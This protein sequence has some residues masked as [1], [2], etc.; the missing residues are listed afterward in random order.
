[1]RV[2][3]VHQNF[4]GQFKSLAPALAAR[5]D[6][7]HAFHMT[8]TSPMPGVTL[9]RSKTTIGTGKDGHPWSRDFDTKIIRAEAT[10]RTARALAATGWTPDVIFAHSGWGEPTFLKLVWPDTPMAIYCEYFYQLSGGDHDFDPEFPVPINL[11]EPAARLLLRNLPQRMLFDDMAGGL[12]PTK[13][14]ADSYPASVLDRITV[15]HDGIDTDA[16]P[17]RG[18]LPMRTAQG[19]A[20]SEDAEVITFVSRNLEPY[21]GY[22]IFMR[23]LPELL[24]RRPNAQVVLVGADG[25]SYGAH[26]PA[27]TT[28]KQ[29]FLD[30]VK[31]RL[32]VNRIHFAGMMPYPAFLNLLRLSSLHVYLTYPFVASWSLC[33][34]MAAGAPILGSATEP[35]EEFVT[36]EETG[37]LFDF[38]DPA[39]LVEGACRILNDKALS[40]RLRRNARKLI[41]DEYD[42]KRVCLPRQI[43]WLDGLAG[44]R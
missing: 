24:R 2:L 12:S 13:F 26:P 28:W 16:L 11:G 36:H 19:P 37:L 32:D 3:L 29:V 30:E 6:D 35:V 18:G 14:Q 15:I 7:V 9:H 17:Y 1:M 23:A 38:F 40:E 34:A 21:R 27:G 8:E 43:A 39:A 25:V 33:E 42:L 31:D 10:L 41:E 22:H 20:L 5:G 4:P 44:A